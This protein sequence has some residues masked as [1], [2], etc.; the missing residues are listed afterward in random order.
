MRLSCT[1]NSIVS[2]WGE[3]LMPR[4]ARWKHL[5]ADCRTFYFINRNKNRLIFLDIV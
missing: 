5:L 1:S 4:F 3:V 2:N